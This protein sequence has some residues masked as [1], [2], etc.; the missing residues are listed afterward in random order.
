MYHVLFVCTGNLCRSPMAHGLLT[1]YLRSWGL[2]DRIAVDSAATHGSRFNEPPAASAVTVASHRGIDISSLRS[3]PI[4]REDFFMADCIVAMDQYNILALHARAPASQAHKIHLLLDFV[5][6]EAGC[7]ISDPYGGPLADFEM[8]FEL[9][10]RG[11]AGLLQTLRE[12][13]SLL[14]VDGR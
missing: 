12:R 9:I 11:V 8:A 10:D 1:D 3:R 14:S 7:E 13:G 6:K 5:G 4:T 2:D